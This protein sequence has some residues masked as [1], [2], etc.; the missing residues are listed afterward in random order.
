[1]VIIRNLILIVSAT[2]ILNTNVV[3][4]NGSAI[5]EGKEVL[6]IEECG[7]DINYAMY[8]FQLKPDGK[9]RMES[10]SGSYSG[11]YEIVIPGEKLSLSLSKKSKSRLY[12]HIGQSSKSLCKVR[13]K[14]LSPRVKRFIVKLDDENDALKAVLLVKYKVTDG[15]TREKGE[16]KVIA[17]TAYTSEDVQPP[18]VSI[19]SPISGTISGTVQVGV[20]ASDDTNVD[21]VKL[22]LDGAQVGVDFSA[23][24]AFTWDTSTHANGNATLE[25]IAIDD[26]GNT[27]TH[28]VF[29][30]VDNQ[31]ADVQPPTV[32]ITSPISGTIS[33]TV[34]VGV[35]ASDDTNVDR[36]KLY[37]DGAQVGVDFSAPYAFTWDTST[38]ANGNATLEAIAFDDADNA[39]NNIVFVTVDNQDPDSGID[40]LCYGCDDTNMKEKDTINRYATAEG[41]FKALSLWR[42]P[43]LEYDYIPQ[44]IHVTEDGFVYMS[45]YHKNEDG[46]SS[47]SSIVLKYSTAANT[48]TD[49]YHLNDSDGSKF[50]AHV[51]GLVVSG[52]YFIVPNGNKLHFFKQSDATSMSGI[53]SEIQLAFK[54]GLDFGGSEYNYKISFL[55]TT[56]DHLDQDVLWTGQFST[57]KT[58]GSHILGYKIKTDGTV[59]PAPLYKFYVPE[60]VNKIQGVTI[61]SASYDAYTLLL[62]RSY[63]SN[64]SYIYKANYIRQESSPY[65]YDFNG[66]NITFTGPA[67]LEDLHVTTNGIWSLSESGANYFQYR[68]TPKPW[69][70]LFPFFIK[71]RKSDM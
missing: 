65:K 26:A 71:L 27:S 60:T 4:L 45:M 58:E 9:W 47:K 3:A 29:V 23:P 53:E 38:H 44:G 12:E 34:Q 39:S 62:S 33:G 1:M 35:S 64:T 55:S 19:T 43:W 70:Q 30:T 61:L 10:P 59:N 46:V 68:T 40:F 17:N 20:S 22:Y 42:I 2:F 48:I 50:K 6:N 57:S 54:T 15:T 31:M 11:K 67:G 51:G 16:Y 14:I 63:G 24:Y 8:N 21:R 5:G 7:K 36:V 66:K 69:D 28:S 41:L 37:L 13:G 32:S 25:A 18:T 49:V 56:K 52:D